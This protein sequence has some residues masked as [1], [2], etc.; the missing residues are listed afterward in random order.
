[1]LLKKKESQEHFKKLLRGGY[2]KE[3]LNYICTDDFGVLIKP[4]YVTTHFKKVVDK[5]GL[6]TLRFHDLRHTCASL[7]LANHIPLKS[8][9]DWLGHANF[10][11]TANIYS[12]LDF[13]SR[14][15]S[16]DKIASVLGEAESSF[17]EPKQIPKK[18]K[19]GR[20][21]KKSDSSE[22]ASA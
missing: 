5:N 19:R 16:A 15:E 20:K 7:L 9:Q 12:H 8:I 1:M 21:P 14:V 17:Y 18:E 11:T 2:C 22:S 4:E 10:E 13:S 3:Y 6:R